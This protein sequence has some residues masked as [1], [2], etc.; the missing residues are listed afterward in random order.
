MSKKYYRVICII[1]MCTVWA[2]W[3]TFGLSFNYKINNYGHKMEPWGTPW[4]TSVR[5]HVFCTLVN[6]INKCADHTD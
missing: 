2:C 1:I 5:L 4:E 6:A 3:K